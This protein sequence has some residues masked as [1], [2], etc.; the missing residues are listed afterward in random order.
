MLK[1][2]PEYTE[3]SS[4]QGESKFYIGQLSCGGRFIKDMD[5]EDVLTAFQDYIIELEKVRR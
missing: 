1:E 5:K 4:L 2:N 3:D